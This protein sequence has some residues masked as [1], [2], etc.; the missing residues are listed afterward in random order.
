MEASSGW[1]FYSASVACRIGQGIAYVGSQL[2]SFSIVAGDYKDRMGTMV[3]S[4]DN[5]SNIWQ[6]NP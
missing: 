3:E 2:A 5:A 6:Q 1:P 4:I